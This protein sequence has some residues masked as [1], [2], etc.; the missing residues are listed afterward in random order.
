MPG[1]R[2]ELEPLITLQPRHGL[3]MTLHPRLIVVTGHARC[4]LWRIKKI[5]P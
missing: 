2:V 3:P 5:E 4:C 1:H